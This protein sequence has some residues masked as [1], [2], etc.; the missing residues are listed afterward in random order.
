MLSFF[1]NLHSKPKGWTDDFSFPSVD[2]NLIF[3]FFFGAYPNCHK[4]H[5]HT[6]D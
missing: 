6:L 1:C 2:L 4:A 3:F 5:E